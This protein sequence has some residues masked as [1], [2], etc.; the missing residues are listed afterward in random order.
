MKNTKSK[1]KKRRNI[2]DYDK[3]N[4]ILYVHFGDNTHES[5]ELYDGSIILDFDKNLNPVGIEIFNFLEEVK[6][7]NKKYK[8]YSSKVKKK[9]G[10][11]TKNRT[12]PRRRK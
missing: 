2:V 12:N 7:F 8:K 9:N 11:K 5:V 10:K 1:N 3:E 4:D 6:K